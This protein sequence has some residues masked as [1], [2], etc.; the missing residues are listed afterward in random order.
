VGP[1]YQT[2]EL[3]LRRTD[4]ERP[5]FEPLTCRTESDALAMARQMVADRGLASVEVQQMGRHLFTVTA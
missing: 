4:A 3:Y 1:L 5:Q 2:Y